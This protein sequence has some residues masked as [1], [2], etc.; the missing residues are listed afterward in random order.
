MATP[1]NDAREIN[2]R[3]ESNVPAPKAVIQLFGPTKRGVCNVPNCA[4]CAEV[5]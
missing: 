1:W 2:D 5:K 4:A 3:F